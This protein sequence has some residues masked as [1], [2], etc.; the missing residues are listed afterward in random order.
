MTFYTA[1]NVALA[2]HL[3]ETEIVSAAL[4]VLKTELQ[5]ERQLALHWF[6]TPRARQYQELCR[7]HI[8]MI[9]GCEK[10]L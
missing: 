2:P 7:Q 8:N 5:A 6:R 10:A 4:E 9:R 1:K 3:Y